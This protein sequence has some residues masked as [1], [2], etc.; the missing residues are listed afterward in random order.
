M[1]QV[2]FRNRMI[3]L[4]PVTWAGVLLLCSCSQ[5]ASP[6]PPVP[7]ADPAPVAPVARVDYPTTDGAVRWRQWSA[8]TISE[9]QRLDRPLLLYLA[10]AGADGLLSGEDELVRSLAEERFVPVRVDPWLHPEL[11]RRYGGGWPTLAVVLPDGALMARAP[12]ISPDR[13]RTFLLRMLAHLQERPETV[14]AR[15]QVPPIPRVRLD[16]AQVLA[17]AAKD[18]DAVY[19]GFGGPDKHPETT[20]LQFLSLYEKTRSGTMAGRMVRRTTDAL[21]ASDLWDREQ[22]LLVYAQTPSWQLPRQEVDVALVAGFLWVLSSPATA[23]DQHAAQELLRFIGGRLWDDDQKAFASRR[24]PLADGE[25]WTDPV[26]YADRLAY[27][28]WALYELGDAVPAELQK[29]RRAAAQTLT[30]L[31][32]SDGRVQHA[33]RGESDLGAAGLLRDQ[34]LVSLALMAAIDVD[35]HRDQQASAEWA[36]VARLAA[37]WAREHLYDDDLGAFRDC[38]Q[39]AALTG[40]M[41]HTP[42]AD[43]TMPAGNALAA[44]LLLHQAELDG[45]RQ[46]LQDVPRTQPLRALGSAAAVMLQLEDGA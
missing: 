28:T 24:L 4:L 10:T 33:R 20:L 2:S 7:A 39:P 22:G 14:V 45:A 15:T 43:D 12:D 8:A 44:L 5:S 29:M 6:P 42:F 19:G 26:V 25:W 35:G 1:T 41:L 18:F 30:T 9:A 32:A 16:P 40:W 37:T 46:L 36:T 17:A 27:L 23:S 34:M 38:Q 3:A 21:L 11:D 13:V 31:V